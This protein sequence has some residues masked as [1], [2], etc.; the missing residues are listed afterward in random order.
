VSAIDPNE[1]P[2]LLS[3]DNEGQEAPSKGPNLTPSDR[4]RRRG[5]VR[6][7][8]VHTVLR[9]KKAVAGLIILAIFVL[10]ALLAT[11][12]FPADPSTITSLG[13]QPPSADHL[14]G[15]TPKGQDV[16]ALTVWG[17]RT[18]LLVGFAVGLTATS[19]GIV[20]GLSAAYFG[21]FIDDGLSLLTN[22]FLLI[23]GLPL[24]VILAAFLPPGIGTVIIVLT[25]T[26][27]A[28][29][30]R[31]L[32]SQALSIRG[33][34]FVASAIVTGEKPTRIMFR[35]ILP[36]MASLVMITLL[37]TVI[38]G[39]G[40]QAGLEFLGLGDPEVISWGTNLYWANN[41]GALLS[42]YWWAFVPS[43]M[44]IALVAFA[45]ALV[46][47]GVDEVSNPRLRTTRRRRAKPSLEATR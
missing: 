19:I 36:N 7:G 31:V 15:T 6:E 42:G 11:V 12:L 32:R 28:G 17:A 23:P 9:N 41:D 34:D 37:G 35:E 45:L 20:I 22:V 26:G 47:Y 2:L 4:A 30:A 33:K 24:L 27:W 46:N 16:L 44:C 8:L 43:G 14:L 25:L 10:V 1:I 13:A 39:I 21:R 40:A 29:S 18:S 3:T 38:F 5:K